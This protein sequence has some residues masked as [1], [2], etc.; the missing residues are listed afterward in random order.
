MVNVHC[1]DCKKNFDIKLKEKKRGNGI[2]E[3]YFTCPH[4]DKHYTAFATDAVVRRKQ[5]EIKRMRDALN[6]L[7]KTDNIPEY[8]NIFHGMLAKQEKL[9]PLMDELKDKYGK[10]WGCG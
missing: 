8:N 4:C 6:E 3:T 10:G 1:D 9:K 5:R 7:N 2:V